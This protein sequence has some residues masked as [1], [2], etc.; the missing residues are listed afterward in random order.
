MNYNN[1]KRIL[2]ALIFIPIILHVTY[3][4]LWQFNIFIGLITFASMW[5]FYTISKFKAVAPNVLLGYVLTFLFVILILKNNTFAPSEILLLNDNIL[6]ISIVV[7]VIMIL[8]NEISKNRGSIYFN[9]GVTF[10]GVIYF[11]ITSGSLISIRYIFESQHNRIG[12]IAILFSIWACDTFAFIFGKKYGVKKISSISPNKTWV[13]AIAGYFGALITI[14]IFQKYASFTL[15]DLIIIGSIVGIFGQVGD[16]FESAFKR[17][18]EVKDSSNFIPGH[19]G[20][21]DRFDSLF[22]VAP[23]ILIYLSLK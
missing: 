18:A 11:G 4:G 17:D 14:I 20:V 9:L 12:M 10:L 3:W 13:G 23:I 1:I 6:F 19:G 21:W 2:V 22:F 15:I 7:L 16:F 5:E 8:L